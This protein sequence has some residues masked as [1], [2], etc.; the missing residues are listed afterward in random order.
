[1]QYGFKLAERKFKVEVLNKYLNYDVD[2]KEWVL[3]DD[4][5]TPD[6]QTIFTEQEL[7]DLNAPK[8]IMNM[9]RE[10]VEE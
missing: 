3:D 10:C 7:K 6:Y 9:P 8:W 1:M 4:T 2:L 5:S